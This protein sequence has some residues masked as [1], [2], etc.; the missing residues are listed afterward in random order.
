ML[1]VVVVLFSVSTVSA[2]SSGVVWSYPGTSNPPAN[3]E[4][5]QFFSPSMQVNVGY[6]VYLPP[7]YESG[8][9]RYPVIYYLHGIQGNEWNYHNSTSDTSQ[10]LP[11]LIESGELPAT[12]LVFP[13]GGKGLNY[14]D[15][16]NCAQTKACP[17]TM[18]I[19]ELIPEVDRIFRTIP[20]KEARAI[21]GFS[22]GGMGATY[23]GL[24]YNSLF[25]SIAA[26]SSA[27][28]QLPGC[29][30]VQ[31]TI[32]NQIKAGTATSP[33]LKLSYGSEQGVIIDWQTNLNALIL[34]EGYPTVPMQVFGSVGHNL[35]QQLSSTANTGMSFGKSLGL[36]H[37]DNFGT[38]PTVPPKPSPS[39]SATPI[40]SPIM[41]PSP[42]LSPSPVA[43]PQQSPTLPPSTTMPSASPKTSPTVSTKP[44]ASRRPNARPTRRRPLTPKE[45][46]AS[47]LNRDGVVSIAD[48]E[49]LINEFGNERCDMNVIADCL[50][51]IHDYN[52]IYE[53]ISN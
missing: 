19:K 52:A 10:S 11:K 20:S 43:S 32:Q 38:S 28:D 42:R 8:T 47:D 16:G 2:Q 41:S 18:I 44:D 24:K 13:N 14:Y 46:A 15:Q 25:S 7:G 12:I 53:A 31:S 33:R 27:C 1:L 39:G 9:Q 50:L 36:F 30:I 26:L 21:E 48:L 35:S 37:W 45:R 6:T 34:A 51:T 17:E 49:L 22:M 40:A 23:L 29:P 4:H 3:I 5:F